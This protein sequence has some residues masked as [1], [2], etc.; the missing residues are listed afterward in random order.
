MPYLLHKSYTEFHVWF[1]ESSCSKWRFFC[2]FC[3]CIN[4]RYTVLDSASV[5]MIVILPSSAI[6]L[7]FHEFKTFCI[8]CTFWNAKMLCHLRTQYSSSYYWKC[9]DLVYF[10][11][12]L[13]LQNQFLMKEWINKQ[14]LNPL[15]AFLFQI[16]I[17]MYYYHNWR[18]RDNFL[19]L[20]FT[21][22]KTAGQGNGYLF[23]GIKC[24]DRL[25]P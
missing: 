4:V 23:S 3:I 8:Y 2:F 15:D 20:R 7:I 14:I 5:L 1:W 19:T 11:F 10:D 18:C 25:S 24:N 17:V 9:W 16:W 12:S 22:H 6:F 13:S 21:I